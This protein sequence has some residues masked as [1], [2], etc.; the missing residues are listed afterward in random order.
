MF[1]N[2]HLPH[3]RENKEKRFKSLTSLKDELLRTGNYDSDIV[4]LM[5]DFNF[6]IDLSQKDAFMFYSKGE[7]NLK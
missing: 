7:T 4:F 3:G 2:L 6:W 5:G 1:A